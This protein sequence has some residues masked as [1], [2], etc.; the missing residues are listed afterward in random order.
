MS[1][2]RFASITSALLTRKGEAAPSLVG[3]SART[4]PAY[5][6]APAPRPVKRPPAISPPSD[7]KRRVVVTLTVEE[8]QRLGIVAAKMN[9]T[10]QEL[11]RNAVFERMDRFAREQGSDCSCIS[12]DA[13]CDCAAPA[14]RTSPALP[15]FAAPAP[16]QPSNL[17]NVRNTP[18]FGI[19]SRPHSAG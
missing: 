15:L 16:G 1:D 10:R 11:V 7:H 3:G 4:V 14:A 9:T 19:A 12:S 18:G 13:A 6:P 8:Y 17:Q 2:A 5:I